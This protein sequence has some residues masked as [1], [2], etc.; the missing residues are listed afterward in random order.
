MSSNSQSS[1]DLA[2]ASDSDSP[3]AAPANEARRGLGVGSKLYIAF[4][5]IAGLTVLAGALGVISFNKAETALDELTGHSLPVIVE[6]LQLSQAGAQIAAAAPHLTRV[7]TLD[8]LRNAS[9]SMEEQVDELERHIAALQEQNVG[10][11]DEAALLASTFT[12]AVNRLS[13][14]VEERLR[15][16]QIRQQQVAAAV[17][18]HEALLELLQPA[19][20]DAGMQLMDS[21]FSASEKTGGAI[22][23]LIEQDVAQVRQVL[24]LDSAAKD[25]Q[26]ALAALA[27]ADGDAVIEA[28]WKRVTASAAALATLAESLPESGADLKTAAG[29]LI[30]ASTDNE[31]PL[32]LR[33]QELAKEWAANKTKPE[34]VRDRENLQAGLEQ[35]V[36]RFD[37]GRQAALDA[38]GT[39]LVENGERIADETGESLAGLMRNEVGQVQ[40]LL[41]GLSEAN[42]LIG[43]IRAAGNE[44]TA[45][46]VRRIS[47]T[48]EEA[49]ARLNA[50]LEMTEVESAPQ[51]RELSSALIA[52]AKG[53]KG[54][55]EL[56]ARE[57]KAALAASQVLDETR[58]T[59]ASLTA[60]V[61]NIVGLAKQDSQAS[62][63]AAK[64]VITQN[65][66]LL[67]LVVIGSVIAAMLIGWLFVGR[68]IVRHLRDLETSMGRLTQGDLD[69]EL[70]S[71]KANDE[72]G[73]MSQAVA[74][75]KHNALE[76]RRL[77]EEK[78]VTEQRAAEEKRRMMLQMADGFEAGVLGV[79]DD[80]AQAAAG[81]RS[82]AQNMSAVAGQASEQ[83]T[84]VADA[85]RN[86]TQHVESVSLTTEQLAS[87]VNE[88]GAQVGHAASAADRAVSEANDADNT[89][90]TL[91][92]FAGRIGDIVDLI[93]DIAEQTN[94]LALNATIEASR[95]G[96]AGKGFA[97]VASEVKSLASQTAEA[98]VEIRK[99]ADG[100]RE[101]S[102]S[103]VDAIKSIAAKIHELHGI[104]VT[105]SA[106]VEEQIASIQEISN[107]SREAAEDTRAVSERVLELSSA[108]RQT[109]DASSGMLGDTDS[110]AGSS[111]NLK[112]AVND[113]L[114][115]IRAA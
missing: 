90:G 106:A 46:G 35:A 115:Q 77:E 91:S 22:T 109:G 31:A 64:Q 25:L 54:V 10:A 60:T 51:L 30:A 2:T 71:V 59:V 6:S 42:R 23:A 9:T 107:N 53:D 69:C 40:Y 58:Q 38:A 48:L 7:E 74:V 111:D 96:D 63:D 112:R 100:I 103:A 113:F 27:A 20:G 82:T 15:L 26:L 44:P 67:A 19:V 37:A 52:T 85:A 89:I 57:L 61:Q 110:L 72:I 70:P 83:A 93:S 56:R 75:F 86:A 28:T 78:A 16:K 11:A 3:E 108:S 65:Q 73:R 101:V 1:P 76:M 94:L 12:F 17:T 47:H 32:S 81:M 68:I 8:A 41:T 80:V 62:S 4:G 88:V 98:T 66:M 92:E 99:Q 49:E 50:N 87:A 84:D 24:A 95:A 5:A 33:R 36:A 29:A 34:L 55:I 102:D 39:R 114:S 43:L 18:A 97:V 45:T 14:Q 79:V 13:G 104:N 105:V 21:A